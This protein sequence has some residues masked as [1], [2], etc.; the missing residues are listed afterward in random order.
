MPNFKKCLPD[1]HFG[2]A[3]KSVAED[4]SISNNIPNSNIQK[5]QQHTA[6]PNAA[7]FS[8]KNK[9]EPA[10]PFV[11]EIL[12]NV[13]IPIVDKI[14]ISRR[15]SKE[16]VQNAIGWAM[17]PKNPPNKCLAA[18]IKFACKSGLSGSE[19]DKKKETVYETLKQ[20]FTNGNFYNNAECFLNAYGIGFARGNLNEGVKFDKYYSPSKFHALLEMFQIDLTQIA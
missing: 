5:E 12:D 18:S 14:E 20:L 7:V 19:F 4:V 8:E 15:Y 17:H 2:V 11:Y 3:D 10:K 16:V 1:R 13:D 9:K 6:P